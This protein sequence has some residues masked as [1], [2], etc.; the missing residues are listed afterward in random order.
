MLT[1]DSAR[2]I[3]DRAFTELDTL[4]RPYIV[5]F[6]HIRDLTS[7]IF[8]CVCFVPHTALIMF[9]FLLFVDTSLAATY[10]IASLNQTHGRAPIASCWNTSFEGKLLNKSLGALVVNICCRLVCMMHSQRKIELTNATSEMRCSLHTFASLLVY[11]AY[12][13]VLRTWRTVH[14]SPVAVDTLTK[15]TGLG[16]VLFGWGSRS[17]NVE[18]EESRLHVI[19]IIYDLLDGDPAGQASISMERSSALIFFCKI[20]CFCW[21]VISIDWQFVTYRMW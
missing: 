20:K 12:K 8:E 1:A 17:A 21:T 4:V 9:M 15:M 14:T 2:E 16:Q 13:D 6:V 5:Q 3:R 19:Y 11:K 10:H 18:M 7:H